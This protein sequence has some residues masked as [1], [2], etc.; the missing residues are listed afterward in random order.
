MENKRDLCWD[1]NLAEDMGGARV[2]AHRPEKK[3]LA[4]IC[5]NEWEGPH[6]GY[7]SIVKIGE[8]YRM[9]YRACAMRQR[10]DSTIQPG[11]GVICMAESCDGGITFKKPNFGKYEYNGTKNNNRR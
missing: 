4:L 5:E 1:E 7:A 3:N 6:N 9:Y 8:K 11:K 10:A 2:C